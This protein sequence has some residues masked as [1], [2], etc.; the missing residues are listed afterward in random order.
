MKL[1]EDP[2]HYWLP[3]VSVRSQLLPVERLYIIFARTRLLDAK[4]PT[5][6]TIAHSIFWFKRAR[7]GGGGWE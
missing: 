2:Y 5:R 1:A 6:R 4:R 3:A 7:A